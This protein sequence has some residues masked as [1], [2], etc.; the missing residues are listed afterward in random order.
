M[1]YAT[2]EG[3]KKFFEKAVSKGV[4]PSHFKE[5]EGLLFSGLGMGSYLGGMNKEVDLLV[6]NAVIESIMSGV[7]NVIDTAINYRYQRAERSIGRALKKL[8]KEGIS[9]EEVFISTK[10]G[11]LTGDDE[12]GEDVYIHVLRTLLE[13]GI[14]SK[15]DI[16]DGIHCMT[17]AFLENQLN[18]SLKNLGLDTIDLMYLHNAVESQQPIV[19]K[20]E[21]L[22]RLRSAFEFFEEARSEG[23]IRYYGMATWDCFRVMPYKKNHFNLETAVNIAKE[24]AGETH[25]FRFV[26]LPFNLAMRE[27]LEKTTQTVNDKKCTILQA[28]SSLGIG[29]FT[30]VPLMQTHLLRQKLPKI[31]DRAGSLLCL[32]FVRSTP[33]IIAPLVGHKQPGHVKE[34]LQLGML[35]PIIGEQYTK[36][37]SEVKQILDF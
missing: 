17:P 1:T 20:E 7:I 32:D 27:A 34:N 15:R 10:N 19:G 36:I 12:L 2:P 18:R 9:R 26:Q 25:G 22:K 11:Y 5:F 23:K 37:L 35:D 28:A 21:F 29:V 24:I 6:E 30:S 8:F 13:P 33:G 4:K 16:V 14:I 31:Q 3:T